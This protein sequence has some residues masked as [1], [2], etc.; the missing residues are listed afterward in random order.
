MSDVA[1]T[2]K[3]TDMKIRWMICTLPGA[4]LLLSTTADDRSGRSA[5]FSYGAVAAG[6]SG[7][8]GDARSHDTWAE[9]EQAAFV[10]LCRDAANSRPI[11]Q[12]VCI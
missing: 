6:R 8:R 2:G 4:S 5:S 10:A 12:Q 9:A 1:D 7:A 11:E 3:G